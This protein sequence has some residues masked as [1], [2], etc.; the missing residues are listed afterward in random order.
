MAA[1]TAPTTTAVLAIA[2]TGVGLSL[3]AGALF[4]WDGRGRRPLT[5]RDGFLWRADVL[6]TASL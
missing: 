5:R 2:T 1:A 3:A 4:A 6:D